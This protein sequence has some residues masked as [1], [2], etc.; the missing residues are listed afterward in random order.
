MTLQTAGVELTG[1]GDAKGLVKAEAGLINHFVCWFQTIS[2]NLGVKVQKR[3]L[4]A[5]Q[6]AASS[7]LTNEWYDEG[8]LNVVKVAPV[9]SDLSRV[10]YSAE[11]AEIHFPSQ[12][13]DR[14]DSIRERQHGLDQLS[15]AKNQFDL[16]LPQPK[17][18][19]SQFRN[20]RGDGQ[21]VDAE[22]QVVKHECERR[23]KA[24]ESNHNCLRRVIPYKEYVGC[25]AA[26]KKTSTA[27]KLTSQ[28]ELEE[29]W[30][31]ELWCPPRST[32][33]GVRSA[34]PS[35]EDE[36]RLMAD[37]DPCPESVA[38]DS[39][40]G[41]MAMTAETESITDNEELIGA[42]GGTDENI[43]TQHCSDIEW[44]EEDPLIEIN[45]ENINVHQTPAASSTP[46]PVSTESKTFHL[47]SHQGVRN[48]ALENQPLHSFQNL[49]LHCA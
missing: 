32:R 48:H 37:Q 22:K 45:D 18:S 40:H 23:A 35:K 4:S 2:A 36:W 33:L 19:Q 28:N 1:V 27:T 10:E 13:Q 41:T 12:S 49:H 34:F 11:M 30:D 14:R 38:G 9:Q 46:V 17:C 24:A 6:E 42:V 5:S 16:R 3:A 29:N 39:G 44:N 26:E 7:V 43:L 47:Q 15:S 8:K 25:R 31:D 20:W 21:D